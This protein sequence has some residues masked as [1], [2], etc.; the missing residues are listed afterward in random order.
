MVGALLL[1]AFLLSI[2]PASA[3]AEWQAGVARVKITPERPMWMSGYASRTAPAEGTELDLWAKAL[4]LDDGDGGR[5]AIV[6]LDIVGI[7][8]DLS[9]A[10]CEE[11]KKQFQFERRQIAISTSH[12]HSG[13]VV[14][15]TL[16]SM[17][18]LDD[19]QRQLVADYTAD[20]ERRIVEL[21]GVAVRDLAP[22]R[23]SWENGHSSIAVNRRTNAEAN[24]PELRSKGLLKGPVDHE[25]PVLSVRSPEGAL[26][27]I[28]FGYACHATVLPF[29]KWS[30]DY[31]G[32]AQRELEQRHPE[33][34]ALFFAGCGGDQNPLPRREVRLAEEYGRSLAAS[35][36]AVLAGPMQAIDGKLATQYAE[37]DLPLDALPSRDDLEAQAKSTDRYVAQRAKLLIEQLNAGKPLAA[38]YPYPVQ[39]WK[40]GPALN[41]AWLGG[42][43]VVDYSLRLKQELGRGKTWVAAYSNDVMAYIPS[44]RVLKEGGYEGGG[45]MVYYGLPTIWGPGVEE[46]IVDGIRRL[47]RVTGSSSENV[48]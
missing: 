12:T 4:V 28:L 41:W 48:K 7:D 18:F 2:P 37:L 43:V 9:Q 10:I 34:T 3:L 29:N 47:G 45:A 5:G 15:R 16:M 25:V 35:V 44:L 38:S 11:L 26:R 46:A 21:V 13:P 24:V 19:V 32:Y 14:G 42:E 23:I 31:P 22:A 36:D 8:R 27:A 20:L 17:Y 39:L 30:G 40:V 1:G 33:A 6:T